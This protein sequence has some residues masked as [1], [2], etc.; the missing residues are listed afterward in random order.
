M[1]CGGS[2]WG[3]VGRSPSEQGE[4]VGSAEATLQLDLWT[5]RGRPGRVEVRWVR[6]EGRRGVRWGRAGE[7][8]RTDATVSSAGCTRQLDLVLLLD[9]S[10]SVFEE[11]RLTVDFAKAVS[12]SV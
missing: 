8:A 2:C 7:R 6:G 3:E 12:F 5:G 9:L 1:W 11:Y 4:G 10:G